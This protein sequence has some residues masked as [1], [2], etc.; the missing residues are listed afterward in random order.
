MFNLKAISEFMKESGMRKT[1]IGLYMFTALCYLI[2]LGPLPAKEFV[3]LT[4]MLI[5]ALFGGNALEHYFEKKP[6]ESKGET[7]SAAALQ[8]RAAELAAGKELDK[9]A[10]EAQAQPKA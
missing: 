2:V 4:T 7:A 10:A 5:I 8:D 1:G 6:D 3:Q 9:K